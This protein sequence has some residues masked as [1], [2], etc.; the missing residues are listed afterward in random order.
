M[1]VLFGADAPWCFGVLVVWWLVVVRVVLACLC[2]CCVAWGL[3][4]WWF[5]VLVLWCVGAHECVFLKG[6]AAP[7]WV[8]GVGV[9]V[10]C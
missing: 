9:L 1:R 3:H 10:G 5:G 7:L 4:P 6:A 2:L 8:G